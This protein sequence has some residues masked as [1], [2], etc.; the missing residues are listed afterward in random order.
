[1][2]PA[3]PVPR[4]LRLAGVLAIVGVVTAA[5]IFTATSP[6][7]L[8]G[9][10]F[11]A[12]AVVGAALVIR[13]PRTSIGW[14]LV[15][16]AVFYVLLSAPVT[17]S[18][19]EFANGTVGLPLTAFAVVHAGLGT[20][21]FFLYA[22]LA[23]VFPSGALP[24]GRWGRLARVGLVVGLLF[25]VAAYLQPEIH[26]GFPTGGWVRNPIALFPDLP[27]WRV[28]T[29]VNVVFPVMILVL[30]G[31]TSLVVRV[32]RARGTERQQLRWIAA[33]VA[34]IVTAVSAGLAIGF[35]VPGTGDSGLAWIPAILAFPSAPIA[36]GIAVLRY[37]LYEIDRIISRTISYGVVTVT[38][39]AVYAGLILLLQAP[40]SAV[41]GGDTIA[42]AASTLV[43]AGLFQPLRRRIQGAV[44][45]RFNRARY[46]A[47]RTVEAF[48]GHLRNEVDLARLRATLIETTD[49]AVH[50]HGATVWLRPGS[51]PGS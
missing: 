32:R 33:S 36:I 25:T 19:E 44:D 3:W 5:A 34:L 12:Y 15:G 9:L 29:P 45:R 11:V 47:Q 51:E 24:R 1:M 27:I 46:D 40:L 22:L 42:V 26:V 8:A 49:D 2:T 35:L 17:A 6:I 21:V 16:M 43:A 28:I 23:M 39:V 50:P 31:A 48:A 18:P 37:R 10:G 13:R 20:T 41:T 38:L 7:G 14:I 4:I 30:A